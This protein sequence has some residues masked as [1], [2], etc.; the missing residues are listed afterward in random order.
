MATA[1]GKLSA[2]SLWWLVPWSLCHVKR[3][4]NRSQWILHEAHAHG[5]MDLLFVFSELK[6]WSCC[7]PHD[8]QLR[9][10]NLFSD[11]M[12]TWTACAYCVPA[13]WMVIVVGSRWETK[14]KHVA[15]GIGS[16]T[17]A[18][19]SLRRYKSCAF[20]LK[21]ERRR[22]WIWPRGQFPDTVRTRMS[23]WSFA[24]STQLSS[25]FNPL[26]LFKAMAF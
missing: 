23:I 4:H 24:F 19:A 17:N 14:T 15:F 7:L 6:R 21:E 20:S 9:R 10:D 11:F 16:E 8:Q 2:M 1:W 22:G 13:D 3:R 5:W 12:V 18:A 26:N 25:V